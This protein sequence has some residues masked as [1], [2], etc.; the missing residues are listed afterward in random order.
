MSMPNRLS[1]STSPYLL[2]HVY[3]PIQWYEWSKEAL[4]KAQDEDKPIL[5]SI[6]YAACHWC[7]VMARETFEDP[8][9]ATIM[10]QHFVCIKVDREARPDIDQVYIEAV[11]AMGLQ[12]GW[13]LHVFLLPNQQPFY[14]GTYFATSAWKELL[15]QIAAAF[16][17][18]RPQL[19]ASATQLTKTLYAHSIGSYGGDGVQQVARLAT[20]QHIFQTIYQDLDLVRGGVQGAPKFP[21]PSVG[22]FLLHYY[23]LAHDQRAL[24]QLTLTL[25]K[26][27]C[28]GIYDQ[29]GGG[30]SRYA[31]DGA[32]LIP[33]FEKMLYDNAQ[34][35]S[36]YAQA[37]LTTPDKLYK[38]VIAQ[39]I[40]CLEREMMD[41]QGGF[42]SSMDA[43][44]EGVEGKFYI[45]TPQ[46]IV[47]ALREDAS[48]FMEYYSMIPWGHREEKTY[49]LARDLRLA[50]TEDQTAKL[51][52]AKQALFDARSKRIK[53]SVDDKILASWNGML[54][55]ALVDAYY[56]L[57]TSHFLE[58][59]C[60]NAAFMQQY[61]MR[62]HQ[63][64]HSYYQGQL[65]SNGY[66]E[67]YAWV[68]R[69]LIS[70]YQATFEETWL[71]QAASLVNHAIQRFWDEE[72]H[73]F[74]STATGGD[75]LIARPREVFDQAIPSSNAIM[76]HNLFYMSFLL[77][78]EDYAVS[79]QQMVDSIMP[80]LQETPLYLTHWASLC[81][82]Q[83][84]Q[85][86]TVAIVGP[87]CKIWAYEIKRRYPDVLLV[88]AVA[89]S[90]IP[91]LKDK[92]TSANQSSVY[93]C[94]GR[95]CQLPVQSLAEAL[96]QLDA[97]SKAIL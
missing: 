50:P 26:M 19:E 25:N 2:Q 52:A 83:L 90:K 97:S 10:N 23:R 89:E 70:L 57:G 48:W 61:L 17:Q 88:G 93:I 11:Q 87:Q 46:E 34:L 94:Y 78:R 79:A 51:Q 53:P 43:D 67:D 56:A 28:G 5:L 20:L 65:G 30:F 80:L 45:W 71:T 91:L 37:Y 55:Q 68:A 59:A 92:K 27:A 63:L 82:L 7:H 12:A 8:E 40:S 22:A 47:H 60:K 85:V 62:D 95:A 6:G 35:I 86:V 33:H 96:A 9:V 1:A 31:T 14:G 36:L 4:I 72:M 74:Y 81:A 39:T 29:L 77:D 42:Y 84:Q 38:E 66:L 18:H 75:E 44:S 13:P 64:S 76:A 21:M 54:L 49:I 69:A 24:D 15:T 41:P 16:Q 32:W 58:L 3:N 73:L